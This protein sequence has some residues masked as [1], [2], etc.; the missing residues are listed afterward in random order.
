ME[1]EY[2]QSLKLSKKIDF[3]KDIEA[4]RQD[5]LEDKKKPLKESGLK[6]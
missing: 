4:E 6:N 2:L 5:Y 1:T 3:Y